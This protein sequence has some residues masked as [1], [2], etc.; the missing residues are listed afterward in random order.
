[1]LDCDGHCVYATLVSQQMYVPAAYVGEA[2]ACCVDLGRAGRVGS[3]VG[4]NRARRH[5]DQAGT[6]MCVPA[7]VSPGWERVLDDIDVRISFHDRLEQPRREVAGAPQVE[8]ARLKVASWGESY[9]HNPARGRCAGRRNAD[10]EHQCDEKW[11]DSY[12]FEV[13]QWIHCFSFLFWFVVGFH[14]DKARN[15]DQSDHLN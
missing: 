4:G 12:F 14:W 9:G 10:D 8:Q 1:N 15:S 3:V 5:R 13:S 7:S 11:Q 6:R 2:L